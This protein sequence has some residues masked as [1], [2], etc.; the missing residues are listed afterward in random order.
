VEL[1]ESGRPFTDGLRSFPVARRREATQTGIEN[2]IR[3][4]HE[5]RLAFMERSIEDGLG[6]RELGEIWGV[7]RQRIDQYLQELKKR[8]LSEADL[9]HTARQGNQASS[10][11]RVATRTH[12]G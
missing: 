9:G 4:R 6:P 3:A 5:F 1:V 2:L 10:A 7:S 8:R 12:K 11:D